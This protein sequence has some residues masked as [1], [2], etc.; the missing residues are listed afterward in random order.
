MRVVILLLNYGR[1]SGEVARQQAKELVRL[2]HGV[3]YM[4]PLVGDGVEGAHNVDVQL[5]VDVLPVHEYLPV[6]GRDQ[7]AVSSMD[8]AEAL[9]YVPDYEAA[10]EEVADDIDVFIGH[11]ANLAAIA[12]H[13]VATRHGKSYVLFLHGTGIEPRLH[14]GYAPEVW[15]QIEAAIDNAAGVIVTTEY[16]RDVLVRPLVNVEDD[17][18]LLLPGGVDVSEFKPEKGEKIRAKYGLPERYVICPGALIT[19]KG[20][21]NVVAA[22][23]E[24]ADLAPVVFIGD[25]DLRD[26]L[27]AELGNRDRV[28]GFVSHEDKVALINAATVLTAAP[29]KLEH[30]GI[31]Y[32]EALAAGT[33]PV[34]YRGGGV[35]SIVS[36]DVGILTERSPNRLGQAIRRVLEDDP[37]ARTMA[38]AGRKRAENE[39]AAPKLGDRLAKW[40]QQSVASKGEQPG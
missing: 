34:A 6:A 32:I 36:Q 4:H 1:G 16:V 33:V 15:E 2:G 35:D 28:L 17:R 37:R 21:Q 29:E 22:A 39:Y 10:V 13:R 23:K 24:F 7:R 38:I 9:A 25:G 12:V 8:A 40:L 30:F 14:G 11:H 3:W 19:A 27:E 20:P 18:L 26:E 5:H 31:I